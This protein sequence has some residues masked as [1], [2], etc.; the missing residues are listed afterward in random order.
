MA[1]GPFRVGPRAEA[2]GD[3]FVKGWFRPVS[4]FSCVRWA[5]RR[6]ARRPI[7]RNG[8]A[9][10]TVLPSDYHLP[11]PAAARGEYGEH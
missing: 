11:P 3:P 5:K 6:S 4:H 2:S 7:G 10:K 9:K 1:L 8:R